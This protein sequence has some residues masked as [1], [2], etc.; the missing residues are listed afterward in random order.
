MN[1][2]FVIKNGVLVKY[3]GTDSDLVI[4]DG[5]NVIKGDF[6]DASAISRIHSVVIPDSVSQIKAEAFVCCEELQEVRL[7]NPLIRISPYAFD[8]C[9]QVYFSMPYGFS[10]PAVKD[11]SLARFGYDYVHNQAS[12]ER[13]EAYRSYIKKSGKRI[14]DSVLWWP[15]LLKFVLD[16]KLISKKNMKEIMDHLDEYEPEIRNL[17]EADQKDHQ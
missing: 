15:D 17:L 11:R 4:P 8:L 7:N 1:H 3:K 12:P 14:Y 10:D 2:D 6:L 9:G 5:V 16:E 13:I